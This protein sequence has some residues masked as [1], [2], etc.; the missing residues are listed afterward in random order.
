MNIC[1]MYTHRYT[2]VYI[3]ICTLT[4]RVTNMHVENAHPFGAMPRGRHPTACF[5]RFAL[6]NQ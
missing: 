1:D 5:R 3:Y 4:L 2:Y 6:Q